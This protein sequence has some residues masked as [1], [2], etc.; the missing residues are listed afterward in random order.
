MSLVPQI[1]FGNTGLKISS[2][3]IGC[4]SYGTKEWVEWVEYEKEKYSRF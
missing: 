3:I 4:M 1:K 2:I